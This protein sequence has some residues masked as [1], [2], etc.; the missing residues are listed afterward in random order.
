VSISSA[1]IDIKEKES[2]KVDK[3]R[4]YVKTRETDNR[5]IKE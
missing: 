1:L 2:S 5:E 4:S 3:Y